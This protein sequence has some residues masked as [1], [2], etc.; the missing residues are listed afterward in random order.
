VTAPPGSS[1]ELVTCQA[2]MQWSARSDSG[3][4]FVSDPLGTT[5]VGAQL[6]RVSNG[7]FAGG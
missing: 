5:S 1:G 6:G 7:V 2:T 4:S 3:F